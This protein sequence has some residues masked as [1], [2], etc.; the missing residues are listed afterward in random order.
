MKKLCLLLSVALIF[1]TV[2]CAFM[3]SH[4]SGQTSLTENTWQ[5]MAPMPTARSELGVAVVDG[6]IYAIGGLAS[7]GVTNVNEK[8]DPLSNT[9]TTMNPMPDAKAI[10]GIATYGDKIYCIGGI[11]GDD[12]GIIGANYVYDTKNNN[13]AS[14]AA[15]HTL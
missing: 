14:I 9:W 12:P 7:Q 11:T 15:S 1:L 5:T 8:Y 3:V 13:W 2:S 4:V 10:F 6:K